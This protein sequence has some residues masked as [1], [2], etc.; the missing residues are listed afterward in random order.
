MLK[1][2]NKG[3]NYSPSIDDL[4]TAIKDFENG[5]ICAVNIDFYS[6]RS[7]DFIPVKI[8]KIGLVTGISVYNYS[9]GSNKMI[10]S[11]SSCGYKYTVAELEY[12]HNQA[13]KMLYP[14]IDS[15]NAYL[16]G[17]VA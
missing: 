14:L 16:I 1:T 11:Y 4:K 6:E 13:V 7:C 8:N 5:T 3:Y 15:M 17:G 2:S 10:F 12:K 9:D